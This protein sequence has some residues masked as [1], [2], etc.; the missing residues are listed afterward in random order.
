MAVATVCVC[1]SAAMQCAR[2][3]VGDEADPCGGGAEY[4]QRDDG[5][6]LLAASVTDRLVAAFPEIDVLR[7]AVEE[8]T[9]ETQYYGAAES[10]ERY[11]WRPAQP[12]FLQWI[13]GGPST[14]YVFAAVGCGVPVMLL[15][16]HTCVHRWRSTNSVPRTDVIAV[17]HWW[18]GARRGQRKATHRPRSRLRRSCA[19]K[20]HA[21]HHCEQ[22]QVAHWHIRAR[23]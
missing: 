4:N 20:V 9:N 2:T 3:R 8:V 13:A 5:Y 6:C 16:V 23:A 21:M 10:P 1:R 14:I 7:E 15:A 19:A 12:M 17:T 11:A 22:L 18:F